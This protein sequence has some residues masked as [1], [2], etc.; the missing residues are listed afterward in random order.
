MPIPSPEQIRDA[1]PWAVLAFFLASAL[2]AMY[3]AFQRRH[4][5]T[6]TE[7]RETQKLARRWEARARRAERIAERNTAALETIAHRLASSDGRRAVSTSDDP[8]GFRD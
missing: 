6:G 3:A 1:G 2:F 8:P 4:I 5:V 7:F